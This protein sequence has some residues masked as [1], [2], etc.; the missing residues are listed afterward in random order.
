[1]ELSKLRKALIIIVSIVIFLFIT[2]YIGAFSSFDIL[3]SMTALASA[4]T[5]TGVLP[6]GA[7]LTQ[8]ITIDGNSLDSIILYI[9]ER[10]YAS[11]DYAIEVNNQAVFSEK[12]TSE[13]A[14]I[15]QLI[16]KPIDFQKGDVITLIITVN[17]GNN[18][19]FYYGNSIKLARGEIGM[20]DLN[21]ETCLY[22]NGQMIYGKLACDITTTTPYYVK[23][24]FFLLSG[25]AILLASIWAITQYRNCIKGKSTLSIRG[26]SAFSN[27]WFMMS[28]MISRDFKTKY[29][30]SALG[31]LWS[32]LN[33]LLTMAVQYLVFSTLF[34]SSIPF[35]PVYLLSGIICYSYFC[36]GA[37]NG[38]L[39]ITGNT[40]LLTKVYIPKYIFPVSRTLSSGI[41][42]IFS[43][44]P[45][46]V[47][48]AIS[49]LPFTKAYL[50]LPFV[51]LCLL[52]LIIGFALMLGTMMV[53]FR[54]IQFLWTVITMMIV[55]TTPIFYPET[56][57]PQ[58][59]LVIF[60]FNP[61]YHVI[62]LFRYVLLQNFTLEPS[63]YLYC[64]LICSI[65]LF[66]GLLVF[67]KNQD[68][69]LLYL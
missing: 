56:I 5:G 9:G 8:K 41:N 51:F 44:I 31:V 18:I 42:F 49:G 23:L 35:Y 59:L 45:L 33:P 40:S 11:F 46:F 54:D 53:F 37:G 20:Q 12:I 27:Y 63:A 19:G 52:M 16:H 38:L 25:A 21:E 28:Q 43:L 32:F 67:K 13:H 29:K 61:L 47:V 64:F 60:K 22:L 39:S 66:I 30:R 24:P 2:L 68:K 6:P 10:S 3:T 34:K 58:N 50:L 26:I 36:E 65:P 7:A 14:G 17:E 15:I 62:R 69:F 4:N 57:L 55:Y 48:V 1:M